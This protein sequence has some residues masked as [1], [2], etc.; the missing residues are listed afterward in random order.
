MSN[1]RVTLEVSLASVK[2]ACAQIS[3]R[4][5]DSEGLRPTAGAVDGNGRRGW[6][7]ARANIGTH[8]GACSTST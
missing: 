2:G 6:Q 4:L 5:D 7:M 8:T 3:A 1:T